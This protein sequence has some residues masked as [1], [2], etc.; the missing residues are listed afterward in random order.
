MLL[1]PLL[2]EI[3]YMARSP[4]ALALL[5]AS[6]PLQA[7]AQVPTPIICEDSIDGKPPFDSNDVPCLLG[8]G[9]PLATVSGSFLPGSVN[10]ATIPYC[11]LDCVHTSASPAQSSAAPG[12]YD[13][14]HHKNEATPENIGWCMYWCVEGYS[15]LVE[16]TACVPSLVYGPPVTTIVEGDVTETLRPFSEPAAWASWYLTQTVLSRSTGTADITSSLTSSSATSAST[17]AITSPPT[18]ASSAPE[19]STTPSSGASNSS[20]GSAASGSATPTAA[21]DSNGG[22]G[23]DARRLLRSNMLLGVAMVISLLL[24][25]AVSA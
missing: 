24:V 1:P 2:L 5:L 10:T 9:A 6:I 21:D 11:E 4:T 17:P 3:M 20:Q 15:S 18:A 19:A 8:C 13:D 12:C 23:N 16:S 7:L 25:S 22:K 14:C